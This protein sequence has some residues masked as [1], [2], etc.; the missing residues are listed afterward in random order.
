VLKAR[1][2]HYGL[3]VEQYKRRNLLGVEIKSRYVGDFIAEMLG[4][5]FE[6]V[7]GVQIPVDGGSDRI[8]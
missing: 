7:T 5:L 8:I 3:T 6:N 1:A 2:A 4:P